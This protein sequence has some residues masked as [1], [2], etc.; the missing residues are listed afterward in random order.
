MKHSGLGIASFAL[1]IVVGVAV[2]VVFA[3]AGIVETTTPGGMDEESPAAI[4]IGLGIF[5]ASGLGLVA[6]G[7]GVASFFQA[8][9]KKLFGILGVVFSAGILLVTAG[10]IVL[11]LMVG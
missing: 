9:R 11:G 10:M 6:L 8:G 7:L 1:S 3:V 2:F 5:G 4:L